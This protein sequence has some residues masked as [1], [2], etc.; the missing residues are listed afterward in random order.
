[1]ALTPSHLLSDPPLARIAHTAAHRSYSYTSLHICTAPVARRFVDHIAHAATV[2][3][4]HI[5]LLSSFLN[6]RICSCVAPRSLDKRLSGKGDLVAICCFLCCVL[7]LTG[8]K[9]LGTDMGDMYIY[10]LGCAL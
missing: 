3:Y 8:T 5:L 6:N 4:R 10:K 1:M 9:V 7:V 2:S